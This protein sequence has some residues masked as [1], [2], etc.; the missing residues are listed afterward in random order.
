MFD[1]KKFHIAQTGNLEFKPQNDDSVEVNYTLFIPNKD[2][3]QSKYKEEIENLSNLFKK[4]DSI[5][6]EDILNFIEIESKSNFFFD[7]S[8][9]NSLINKSLKES[10]KTMNLNEE[11]WFIVKE[12]ESFVFN[13]LMY[14]E[15]ELNP[16][17]K[18]YK[19]KLL[20][21]NKRKKSRYEMTLEE[22][23]KFAKENK[24]NGI[25]NFKK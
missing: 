14:N 23:V 3:K 11:A 16:S 22:K 21:F 8:D 15:I 7:L 1:L 18:L 4:E 5:L 20:D 9:E 6:S 2:K 12:E 17:T 10:I 13:F 25:E 24:E 19:I